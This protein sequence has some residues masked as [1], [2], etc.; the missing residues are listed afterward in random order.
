MKNLLIA[1]ILCFCSVGFASET[2]QANE[3]PVKLERSMFGALNVNE[4]TPVIQV[5]FPYNINTEIID[6]RLSKGGTATVNT[7]MLQ[8]STG[9][10]TTSV[11]WAST[12]KAAKYHPGQATVVKVAAKFSPCVD[13]NLQ[14]VGIGEV[15]DGYAI[16][17]FNDTF[18]TVRA[19]SGKAEVWNLAIDTDAT[20]TGTITVTL[21]GNDNLIGILDTDT[22]AEI[23]T[24][25]RAATW[26]DVGDGWS[27]FNNG[28]G[29]IFKSWRS[30]HK[31]GAFTF[32]AGGTG[33]TATFTELI[34]GVTTV[35]E[36]TPSTD[37]SHDDLSW[38]DITKGNVWRIRYQWLGFGQIN[39]EVEDP[40]A[41]R[42]IVFHKEPY[43]NKNTIPSVQNPT[44]P[45]GFR[46]INIGGTSTATLSV[47]SAAV[48]TE[49][50]I[51]DNFVSYTASSPATSV[52]T[53]E[54][55]LLT[56]CNKVVYGGA[57]PDGLINRVIIEPDFLS[58]LT[59]GA[60]NV[61]FTMSKN[62]ELLGVP[63]FVDIDTNN[64]VVGA[65]TSATGIVLG[66][67][68]AQFGL[69]KVD[70]DSRDLLNRGFELKPG[71]TLS[72][73]AHSVSGTNAQV[74]NTLSWREKF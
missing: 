63:V 62:S 26:D 23:A 29:T 47:S 71:D 41:G 16:G 44:M 67:I 40:Q 45:M 55:P 57:P 73:S 27:D 58:M 28:V 33:A 43:V 37:F 6:V 9:T 24:K 52:D 14:T 34:H 17:C 51:L 49:G 3:D 35:L 64:S 59:D 25:I 46:T 61:V 60:Q 48:F 19:H 13:G 66:R 4:E 68:L 65:D 54:T 11:A 15:G 36:V 2:Q 8:L 56:I 74:T 32:G 18:S 12:L 38:V 22:R 72:V 50:K 5:Q 30:G 7:G 69:E 42:F 53:D 31:V 21:N 20:T 39:Y 70:A 1:F 10:E